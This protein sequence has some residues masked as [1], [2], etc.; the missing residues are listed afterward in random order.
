MPFGGEAFE[1]F[2]AAFFRYDP[3]Y[4][5]YLIQ[6]HVDYLQDRELQH[7]LGSRSVKRAYW[8]DIDVLGIKGEKAIVVS[9]DENC[10]KEFEDII[11]ELKFAEE[12]V[13]QQYGVTI[14]E[15]FYAFSVG[16]SPNKTKEKL[17]QLE[18]NGVKIITFVDMLKK[19][20]DI[21]REKTDNYKESAGKFS[22]PIIWALREI[23]MIQLKI[24][25]PVFPLKPQQLKK[26][27]KSNAIISWAS[28]KLQL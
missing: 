16:W 19:F 11:D 28:E 7:K 8:S 24:G 12:Y 6:A 21:I 14:V 18:S 4:S 25:E 15:K 22:E 13:K 20:V 9:C 27:R 1:E 17:K 23:D 10:G 5:G 2:T 3:N 26:K